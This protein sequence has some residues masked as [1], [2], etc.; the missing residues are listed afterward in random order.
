MNYRT[1]LLVL[2]IGVVFSICGAGYAGDI[3]TPAQF[4]AGRLRTG[5]FVY[6]NVRGDQEIG[7]AKISVTKIP[8]TEN[9]RFSNLETGGFS[10]HWTAIATT[11]LHPISANLSFGEEPPVFDLTYTTDRVTGFLVNRKGLDAGARRL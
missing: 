11:S 5:T 3:N 7:R 10:Q 9:F 4:D 6:R 8:G 1:T 2:R